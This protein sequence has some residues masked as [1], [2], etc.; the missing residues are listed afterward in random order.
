MHCA[1]FRRDR[2]TFERWRERALEG[3]DSALPNIRADYHLKVGIGFAR[4]GNYR[5]AE[6]ELQQA[7]EVATANDLH[8]MTF[9]VE[10]IQTGL[11]MCAAQDE[12]ENVVVDYASHAERSGRFPPPWR[13]SVREVE[14]TASD[15]PRDCSDHT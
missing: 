3:L 13:H 9:R 12:A 14:R 8:E 7:L 6:S 11:D 2:V 1:S 15:T 5:R 4:F 10:R